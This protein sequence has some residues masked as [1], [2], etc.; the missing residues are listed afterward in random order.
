MALRRFAV[1]GRVLLH[2][3]ESLP[4]PRP[5]LAFLS[6]ESRGHLVRRFSTP[7]STPPHF[8]VQYLVSKCGLS[9]AAAAKAAPRFAHLDSASRP[10]A[11][12][13]FLRSQG[14]T[15]AQVREVVSWKPELLLSDVDATLD[16]KFRAVRALGL[17]RA[18]VARLFALYPPALTYGIHTNLLPRVLFWIDFLG[19]AKLLMKW[20]AKTWLLRYSVDA[21]LRNLSTLRSLGVQQSRI[22]TTVRM[23][24]TLITQTPARFQKLVGRV[25]ACGVPPSSGMYMWAFFALHNVSEGS[26]RAKK[27]AV[28]GA[29]GCTEE[30]FDAMF[31]RAPCLVFVPAALLRRK[32]EFLMAEA[33]CD[34][35]HIVT[36]PVLLTLS[37]GKRM[38]P[39]CRVVEALR[40]RGVGI[41]KKANLGSVMR[42]PED[43]F[44][45]RYVLRYKEEV[46]ELLEL[47]PPRLCKG[48]S[49]TR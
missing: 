18:D 19:S 5:P 42:Y 39:R 29:A 10:D 48:S 16:P 6:S 23:Q 9:P 26:F 24:P 11:A 37:L 41:G 45:E 40:S 4:P 25:E 43:K 34:A 30:E 17:G 21:L 12:L 1:A 15:R 31:R 44:V 36:N 14:L 38:A 49:Q 22:T 8:M 33:G 7:S 3:V 47:Y 27:A 20:L 13:A 28:V 32:V 46:P 2:R 35:T